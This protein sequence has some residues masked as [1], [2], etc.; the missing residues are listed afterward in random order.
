MKTKTIIFDADGMIIHGERFSKRLASDFGISIDVIDPFFKKEFQLCLIGQAD[1]KEELSKVLEVW[2]WK[3]SLDDLLDFWFKEEYNRIDERFRPSIEQLRNNEVKVYLATNNEKY[4]T[5]NLINERG[6]GK[7]F[8][9]VFSSAYIG[10]KKPDPLFFQHI[11]DNTGIEK[12]TTVY[13]DDD[14][15]NIN[16][17]K[18][19]GFKAEVYKDFEQ[20]KK[21]IEELF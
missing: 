18:K 16:G 11:L 19:F 9:K 17:A 7:L 1:L 12:D 5:D 15:E 10:S 2:G 13:W 6:L 20:Y 14:M 4:R 3:K 21:T 8:N